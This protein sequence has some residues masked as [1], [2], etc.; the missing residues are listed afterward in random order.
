MKI[1]NREQ[2][3][4]FGELL[5]FANDEGQPIFWGRQLKIPFGLQNETDIIVGLDLYCYNKDFQSRWKPEKV[6]TIVADIYS[7]YQI[8]MN[9]CKDIGDIIMQAIEEEG[10]EWDIEPI[11]TKEKLYSQI[12]IIQVDILKDSYVVSFALNDEEWAVVK[13]NKKDSPSYFYINPKK[14]VE[15]AQMDYR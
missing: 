5:C 10:D 8:F 3:D 13:R 7:Q 6:E 14:E 15:F 12:Q 9:E 1:I 11:E 2:N 4:L